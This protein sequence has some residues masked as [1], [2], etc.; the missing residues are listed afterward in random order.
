MIKTSFSWQK[1]WHF[2]NKE[3]AVCFQSSPTVNAIFNL[4]SMNELARQAKHLVCILIVSENIRKQYACGN[5]EPRG[6]Q[7]AINI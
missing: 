5:D 7:K 2:F 1:Q 4:F 3:S 6:K